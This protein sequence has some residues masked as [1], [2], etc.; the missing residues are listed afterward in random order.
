MA[1]ASKEGY[2]TRQD[3][4][5]RVDHRTFEKERDERERKRSSAGK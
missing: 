5:V 3:F 4:L 2:L 1:A